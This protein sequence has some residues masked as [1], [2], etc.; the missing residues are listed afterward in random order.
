M[1]SHLTPI[2]EQH[3]SE[4]IKQLYTDIKQTFS[5]EIIPLIFQYLANFEEYFPYV[6]EKMK[7]NVSHENFTSSYS[8]AISFSQHAVSAIYSPSFHM[9]KLVSSLSAEEKQDLLTTML[10]LEAI[11]AKLLILSIGL[12]ENIK[13]VFVGLT[14]LD[15][16]FPFATI[17]LGAAHVSDS[18]VSSQES[19]TLEAQSSMLAPL[20]G[21][22]ALK[23]SH[24]PN[25]FEQ[26]AQEME[27]LMK[28]EKYLEQRVRLE[29]IALAGVTNLPYSLGGTY[30]EIMKLAGQ[31]PHFK[32]LFYLL[33]ETF[34]SAFPRLLLT[35][36]LMKTALQVK[37]TAIHI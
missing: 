9:Q 27:S 23:I 32:Q 14:K 18:R 20:F 13:G 31:K 22:Q 1:A 5:V 34:P 36:A 4:E 10:E 15:E 35:T 33:V 3:A 7:K 8:E 21:S 12:R 19:D 28:T 30:Q 11:N 16:Q 26:T 25:F 29:H 37:S 6:L 2:A 24:I 17:H